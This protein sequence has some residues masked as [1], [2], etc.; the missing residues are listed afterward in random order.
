MRRSL[1]RRWV[2]DA[3]RSMA[4]VKR[5]G[6]SVLAAAVVAVASGCGGASNQAARTAA[7]VA[8]ANKICGELYTNRAAPY[9]TRDLAELRALVRKD[10]NL[11]TLRKLRADIDAR[12][13]LTK[14]IE[15]AQ[16]YKSTRSLHFEPLNEA[17]RLS[18]RVYDDEKALGMTTCARRP[19]PPSA[20]IGG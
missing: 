6:A 11:P 17:Y 16:G 18:V 9:P 1:V 7:F 8:L 4:A 5:L 14:T 13:K 15:R 2:A 3:R 12:R 19:P 10:R 20:P